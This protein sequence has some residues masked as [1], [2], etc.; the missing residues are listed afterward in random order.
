MHL[1][2]EFLSNKNSNELDVH[3][4]SV[5]IK[6]VRQIS[7]FSVIICII[8]GDVFCINHHTQLSGGGQKQECP[9]PLRIEKRK[10]GTKKYYISPD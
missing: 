7:R 9:P 1:L 5:K 4:I 8:L 6:F 2:I 10:K 3:Q